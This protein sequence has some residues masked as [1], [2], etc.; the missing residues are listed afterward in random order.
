MTQVQE[1]NSSPKNGSTSRSEQCL[2]IP[3][4]PVDMLDLPMAVR[5][6]TRECTKRPLYPL[7]NYV[8]LKRLSPAHK[9]SF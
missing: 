1:S 2:E 8:S 9:N 4:E 7:S 5:K 3:P 6:G